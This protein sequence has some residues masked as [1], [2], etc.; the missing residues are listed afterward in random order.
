MSRSG[1]SNVAK[2]DNKKVRAGHPGIKKRARRSDHKETM[3]MVSTVLIDT[4]AKTRTRGCVL[5]GNI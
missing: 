3:I 5:V 1:K 2:A 4:G